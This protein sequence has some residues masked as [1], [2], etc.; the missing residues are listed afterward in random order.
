MVVNAL[1]GI[2]NLI[3]RFGRGIK[4]LSSSSLPLSNS[5]TSGFFFNRESASGREVGPEDAMSLSAVFAAIRTRS[6][7]I[8]GLPLSINRE[9]PNGGKEA[10]TTNPAYKLLRRRPNPWMSAKS[11]R[12]TMEVHRLLWGNAYAEIIWNMG[13]GVAELWLLEPW[14]VKPEIKDGELRYCID[15]GRDYIAK[16][17]MLHIPLLSFDGICGRGVIDFARD[18]L[19]LN[20][21]AQD[22]AGAFFA[23]GATTSGILVHTGSPKEEQKKEMREGWEKRHQGQG[24]GYRTGVLWGGWSYNADGGSVDPEKS[25]L[26]EQRLFGV[27][28]VARWFDMPPTLLRDLSRATWSNYE[29][30]QIGAVVYSWLPICIDYEQEYDYKLLGGVAN[31][32]SKHNLNGLLRGNSKNR[33]QFYKELFAVGGI[34]PNRICELEDENPIGPEGDLRFVPANM[35]S[36]QEAAKKAKGEPEP[37]PAPVPPPPQ[38]EQEEEPEPEAETPPEENQGEL[39]ARQWMQETLQRLM[40]KEVNELNRATG[41]PRQFLA[42]VDVFYAEHQETL[43]AALAPAALAASNPLAATKVAEAWITDSKQQ[44]LD[45]SGEVTGDKLPSAVHELAAKWEASRAAEAVSR[46]KE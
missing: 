6:Q 35:M 36:L 9:L 4:S 30:E 18:S 20:L 43:T 8:G 14:R 28:E 2:G 38:I 39:V 7:V 17:D 25:Q 27:S 23:N 15:G 40:R 34:T 32:Y 33:A 26:L 5:R 29:D 13:G 37:K 44:L 10:A 11:F 45:L 24:K 21:S 1:L 3:E 12:Q 41:K 31:L 22:F 16:E 42:W 19:G 46:L